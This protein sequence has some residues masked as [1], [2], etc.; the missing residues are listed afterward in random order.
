MMTEHM[1]R[2]GNYAIGRISVFRRVQG[3]KFQCIMGWKKESIDTWQSVYD[4]ID[5]DLK[6]LTKGSIIKR[7]TPWTMEMLKMPASPSVPSP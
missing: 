7:I 4:Q 1:S 2:R 3:L 6:C 5:V